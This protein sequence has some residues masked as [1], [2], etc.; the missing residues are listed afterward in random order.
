MRCLAGAPGLRL[1][2]G[3]GFYLRVLFMGF[4]PQNTVDVT[5]LCVLVVLRNEHTFTVLCNSPSLSLSL[6]HTC[7]SEFHKVC[8]VLF[9]D[10]VFTN[11]VILIIF[12]RSG[13]DFYCI[14]LIF[15]LQWYSLK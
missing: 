2:R 5:I 15:S 10:F 14:K 8:R 6:S 11:F 12:F 1:R 4:L 9:N 13:M 7:R 3:M